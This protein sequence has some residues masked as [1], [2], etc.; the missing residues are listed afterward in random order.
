[1]A[2]ICAGKSCPAQYTAAMIFASE[3]CFH[4]QRP[5][6]CGEINE[7]LRLKSRF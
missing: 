2:K 4:A 5:K 1:M 3:T 7:F 6:D